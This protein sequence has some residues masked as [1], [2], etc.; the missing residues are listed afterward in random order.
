MYST[1]KLEEKKYLG[2]IQKNSDFA[3][4]LNTNTKLKVKICKSF[5]INL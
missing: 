1:V 5:N 3:K 2:K 4:K